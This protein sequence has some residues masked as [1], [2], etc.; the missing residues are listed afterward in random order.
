MSET[1]VAKRYAKSL[2]DLGIENK[3]ADKLYNDISLLISTIKENRQL[4]AFF[5]SPIINTDKKDAVLRG[6]FE[7]KIDK[8][9]LAFF[10]I[11]TRK[12]R[13]YYIEEIAHAFVELYKE[14]NHQQT[15]WLTTAIPA[16]DEIRKKMLDL[17]SKTTSDEIE[18]IEN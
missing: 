8:M 1:R 13:E 10:R 14:Y 6:I 3:I 11:V 18:L 9:T 12:K 7:G 17:I 2:L 15:A 4:S 16:D 5:K